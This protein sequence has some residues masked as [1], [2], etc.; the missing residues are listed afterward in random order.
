M[1]L[2]DEKSNFPNMVDMIWLC[3][4]CCCAFFF[5]DMQQRE[6]SSLPKEATLYDCGF[7]CQPFSL[8]HNKS[9]LMGEP[10]AEVFREAIK[11][12]YRVK[13]LVSVLENVIGIL[14]VWET[15]EEYLDKLSG[16]LHCRVI[17]DPC[18]LGDCTQQ[19]R[20]YI[21]LI[22]KLFGCST[23]V[24]VSLLF[25]CQQYFLHLFLGVFRS[26]GMV[27]GCECVM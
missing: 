1:I 8:L 26:L 27:C 20:V 5:G 12:I 10:E 15:V 23:V 9:A 13:P 18:K 2:L 6:S 19:R 16:Y 11:T 22:H 4:R 17:I 24:H 14:R 3:H 7:P 25:C 21:L